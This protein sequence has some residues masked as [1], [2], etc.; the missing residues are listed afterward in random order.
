[1]FAQ[2]TQT[3][4]R[5]IARCGGWTTKRLLSVGV[6]AKLYLGSSCGRW[7]GFVALVAGIIVGHEIGG[8]NLALR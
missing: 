6:F 3:E 4:G 1:M 5:R 8:S 2:Y 7:A